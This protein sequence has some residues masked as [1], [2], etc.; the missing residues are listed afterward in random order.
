VYKLDPNV[1]TAAT[2]SLALSKQYNLKHYYGWAGAKCR[3]DIAVVLHPPQGGK[4]LVMSTPDAEK[5]VSTRKP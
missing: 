3:E 5:L 1:A 2:L 4:P